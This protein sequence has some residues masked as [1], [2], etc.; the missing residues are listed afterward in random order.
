MSEISLEIP[1]CRSPRD[2]LL[3]FQTRGIQGESDVAVSIFNCWA[4]HSVMAL[5][6]HLTC[7]YVIQRWYLAGA[8]CNITL[9]LLLKEIEMISN[10]T[11]T[12]VCW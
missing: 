10:S 7:Y 6:K 8:T 1:S 4:L 2:G 12:A 9:N 11:H 5:V 3:Q